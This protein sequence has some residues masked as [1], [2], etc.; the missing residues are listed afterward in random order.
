MHRFI[1]LALLLL[2]LTVSAQ[3]VNVV[4]ANLQHGTGTDEITN[5][6][7]QVTILNTTLA[8]DLISVQERSTGNTGWNASLVAAG[9]VEAVYRENDAG[10]S[11]GPAI[12]YRSS[13]V[14]VDAVYNTG[15]TTGLI[16]PAG[17]TVSGGTVQR[18]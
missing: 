4:T 9:F 7:R 6:S 13:R 8:G 10:Q 18:Q 2:P 11:D 5:Y 17:S 1:I 3:T 14:Q 12:W 15:L 16:R